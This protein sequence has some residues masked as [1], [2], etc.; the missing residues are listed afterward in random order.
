[1][2]I[3]WTLW[4]SGWHI[5]SLKPDCATEQVQRQPKLTKNS[6]K[7]KQQNK[8]LDHASGFGQWC[9]EKNKRCLC[10]LPHV[11]PPVTSASWVLASEAPSSCKLE[12]QPT[13]EVDMPYSDQNVFHWSSHVEILTLGWWYLDI[14]LWEGFMLDPQ[15]SAMALLLCMGTKMSSMNQE[16]GPHPTP[17]LLEPQN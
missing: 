7:T 1:M 15:I 5:Y 6:L 2:L 3:I 14:G 17:N 11:F 12:T 13:W 4:G 16:L 9:M 10:V 8:K